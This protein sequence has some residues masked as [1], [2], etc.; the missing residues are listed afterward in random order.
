MNPFKKITSTLT[1]RFVSWFLLVSLVPA[2]IVATISFFSAQNAL[3]KVIFE[4]INSNVEQ[5]ESAIVKQIETQMSNAEF[6]ASLPELV[7][8]T[9]QATSTEKNL[10]SDDKS[11][12]TAALKGMLA[13]F[14]THYGDEAD[15]NG[16]F[17]DIMIADKNGDVFVSTYGS[18]NINESQSA[19]FS[20]GM[21]N[22][23]LGEIE[24]SP[25]TDK[26][27]QVISTP[28]KNQRGATIAVLQ[29]EMNI[30]YLN[31]IL[32]S[33]KLGETGEVYLLNSDQVMLTDSRFEAGTAFNRVVDTEGVRQLQKTHQDLSLVHEDYLGH[34][35]I[36]A[37]HE[38]GSSNM[39]N[40]AHYREK[41]D[42]LHWMIVGEIDTSEAFAEINQLRIFVVLLGLII[43]VVVALLSWYASKSTGEFVKRPL[44]DVIEQITS[45]ATQLSSSSQQASAAS[46]QNASIAQQLAT[47]A[48]QQS[49]QSEEVSQSISSMATAVQQMSASAQEV[50]STSSQVAQLAQSASKNGETSQQNLA[51]IKSVISNTSGSVKNL[52]DKSQS[53]V[54]I[55]NTIGGIA[56]QTNLLA[57]NAAIEA[58]RAGDAGRGFAVVADEVRKLA[59]SSGAATEEIQ[60]MIKDMMTSIDET[61]T[62][63]DDGNKSIEEGSKVIDET[64]SGVQSIAASIQQSTSKTQEISAAIQQQAAAIQQVAKTMDSI[65]AVAEQNSSGTQQLSVST[66]QQSAANQQVAA[67]AQQLQGLAENVRSLAGEVK[68]EIKNVLHKVAT[69]AAEINPAEPQKEAPKNHVFHVE[70][71]NLDHEELSHKVEKVEV[72]EHV[73]MSDENSHQSTAETHNN[74]PIVHRVEDSKLE[75]NSN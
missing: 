64:L 38:F 44:R 66:Q 8:L 3:Q 63:V 21:K 19:W 39:V 53:I 55:V 60:A 73:H 17:A 68:R 50:S 34:E 46:Q 58:A 13:D 62:T 54:E 70:K 61:V 56:K 65:A 25:D 37:V 10:S 5:S 47:G 12:A 36:A 7:K 72:A 33:T 15:G 75:E 35:V 43:S 6:L 74:G 31:Q 14:A 22:I 27:T 2:A 52:A 32:D 57:L 67:S 41:I 11:S 4:E 40:R 59:E 29:L 71:P 30:D 45:A 26:V 16:I 23:F 9:E 28:I 20:Q 24:L 18:S 42:A 49:R 1:G 48:S 69:K 51:N